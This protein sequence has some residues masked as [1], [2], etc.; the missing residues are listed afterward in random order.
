M[1]KKSAKNPVKN[2]K[3]NGARSNVSRKKKAKTPVA[4][5]NVTA[6]PRKIKQ[7]TYKS[8]RLSKP[9]KHPGRPLPSAWRLLRGSLILLWQHKVL[10]GGV[11]FIY[12]LLQ[13]L[14]V[15]GVL[16]AN[17]TETSQIVEE[18]LGSQW[19]GLA[20]GLTLFSYLVSSAGQTDTAE[21]S[22]YQSLLL[23]VV[24]LAVI[25]TLR[26][27]LAGHTVR[28]RDAYYKGMYPL[29]PFVLVLTVIM[30]QTIPLLIGAWLY[31]TV[32]AN[33]IAVKVVEQA[34]WVIIFAIFGTLSVYMICSSLFA[35]YIA[36]LPDMAPMK[37][38]R[39]ARG[40]VLHRRWSVLRKLLFL[41]FVLLLAL[42]CILVPVIV[43]Y[44]PAAPFV[45]FVMSVLAVGVVHTYLYSLYRELLVDAE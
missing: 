20:S 33:G 45:F 16:R 42:A 15:Q 31:Q 18:T 6:R 25:W 8:F 17:F 14:L 4:N 34:F 26:Q 1:P 35:L 29:V 2:T 37:A 40:L 21:A 24:S 12:A 27:V 13:L 32:V 30:L 28:A 41:V 10:F 38:L 43:L 7:P 11:L 19:N 5:S 44:A 22:V 9:I 39:S 36:T 23:L 3:S